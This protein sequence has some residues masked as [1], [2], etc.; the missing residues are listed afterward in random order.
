[1]RK[2]SVSRFRKEHR[3][4]DLDWDFIQSLDDKRIGF[5]LSHI[6][7][8]YIKKTINDYMYYIDGGGNVW[9]KIKRK[10]GLYYF[11]DECQE[12]V[13]DENTDESDLLYMVGNEPI[14][15]LVE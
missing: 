10:D 13:F 3:G 11:D 7:F 2:L 8:E 1:M 14:Y 6:E 15:R 5:P 4:K 12:W 9:S